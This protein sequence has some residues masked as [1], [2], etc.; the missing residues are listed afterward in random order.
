MRLS[1]L[2]AT[3]RELAASRRAALELLRASRGTTTGGAQREFW[4]EFAWVDQEYR[5]AVHR[6]AAFCLEHRWSRVRP[7]PLSAERGA[8]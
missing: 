5:V 4:L 1:A 7:A 6:L 3:V 2:E 8:P